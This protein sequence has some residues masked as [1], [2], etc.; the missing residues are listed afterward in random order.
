MKPQLEDLC[1]N[2][3]TPRINFSYDKAIFF[4]LH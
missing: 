1:M 2:P 4:F 3:K